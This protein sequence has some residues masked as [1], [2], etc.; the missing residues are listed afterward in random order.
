MSF[1]VDPTRAAGQQVGRIVAALLDDA[2]LRLSSIGAA[3][4]ELDAGLHEVRRCCKEAR[5]LARLVRP[6]L[7]NGYARFNE[8]VR[9]AAREV[10]ELRDASALV[11]ALD[12]LADL[13]PEVDLT[14]VRAA[15]AELAAAGARAVAGGDPRIDRSLEL[16]RSARAEVDQWQL[17]DGF[18]VLASGL[19]RTYRRSRRA[20]QAA[21]DD[22]SDESLHEWRRQTKYLWYQLRLLRRVAPDDLAPIIRDLKKIGERLGDDHDLA[23]LIEQVSEHPNRFGSAAQIEAAVALAGSRRRELRE[24]AFR[25]AERVWDPGPKRF[26]KL[27]RSAWDSRAEGAAEHQPAHT[28]S[29]ERERKF[30]VAQLPDLDALDPPAVLRQGYLAQGDGASTRVRGS[31]GP[32]GEQF[33]L[34]VKSGASTDRLELELPISAEQFE[35]AWQRTAGQRVSK[36]R[37]LI[38]Y[39]VHTIELDVF[40]EQLAGLVI[41]EVE[42]LDPASLAAFEPPAWFGDEVTDDARYQNA[43][44]ATDGAP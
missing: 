31:N 17:G 44:L 25:R 19:Q 41:A 6:H 8:L 39:G 16:L 5:A 30:L 32:N 20:W 28:D 18:G 3:P 36:R 13:Q 9:D 10:S 21:L 14:E 43:A 35:A 26:V 15:Q 42:F 4:G 22:P 27:V 29:T 34:T 7:G 2:I 1:A 37:Y 24:Q 33:T 12:A 11:G 38:P 23:V 40:D